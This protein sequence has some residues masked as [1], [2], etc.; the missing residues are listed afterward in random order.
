[1]SEFWAQKLAELRGGRPVVAQPSPVSKHRPWWEQEREEQPQQQF[2]R[3]IR[4]PK[5]LRSAHLNE[6]CPG[7]GSRNYM[8]P[9]NSNARKRCYDCGFPIFQTGSDAGLPSDAS[10]PATPARQIHDG[11]SNYNPRHIV[12]RVA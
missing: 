12:A 3:P 9:P 6:T 2:D 1:M 11:S 10:V 7:C 8:Q 4:I 5:G